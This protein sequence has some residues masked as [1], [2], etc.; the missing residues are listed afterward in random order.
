MC[1]QVRQHVVFICI[2][3]RRFHK[4][5][6]NCYLFSYKLYFLKI[7]LKQG[8]RPTH[9][10]IILR[11]TTLYNKPVLDI[12]QLSYQFISHAP[13]RIYV[14]LAIILVFIVMHLIGL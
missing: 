13:D 3:S 4:S 7:N 8:P 6:T 9:L 2:V 5:F 1:I 14:L 12:L 11:S 10:N